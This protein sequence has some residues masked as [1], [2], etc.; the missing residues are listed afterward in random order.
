MAYDENSGDPVWERILQNIVTTLEAIATPSY[1]TTVQMVD[2]FEDNPL[3]M[4]NRLPAILVAST[5]MAPRWTRNFLTEYT[6][7]VVLRFALKRTDDAE[8]KLARFIA[9]AIVALNTD[10]HRGG[11]AVETKTSG[12]IETFIFPGTQ[13]EVCVAD[14]PVTVEFRHL[15]ADPTQAY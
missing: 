9:D 2:R 1:Q 15:S 3:E 7:E 11:D 14:M 6:M 5:T 10:T 4:T 12:E 8:Q 13:V